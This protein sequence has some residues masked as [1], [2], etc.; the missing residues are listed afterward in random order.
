MVDYKVCF[1]VGYK[2]VGEYH[3]E[4]VLVS[5]AQTAGLESL[6]EDMRA[7]HRAH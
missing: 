5:S 3:V 2:G 7:S 4:L 6:L 1:S